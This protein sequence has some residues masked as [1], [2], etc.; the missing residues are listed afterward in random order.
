MPFLTKPSILKA[1]KTLTA[2][3]ENPAIQGATQNVS[4]LRYFFALD[5]FYF[6]RNHPC[7]TKDD[8]DKTEFAKYVGEFCSICDNLY[9]T[10]FYYPLKNHTGDFAVGSNFYSV[11]KVKDSLVNKNEYFDYPKRGNTPL[12]NI[13]AGILYKKD[14]YYN[15]INSYLSS[16]DI[17]VALVLWLLR[18]DDIETD[19]GKPIEENLYLAMGK[20]YSDNLLKILFDK[21]DEFKRIIDSYNIKFTTAGFCPLDQEDIKNLFKSQNTMNHNEYSLQVIFYGAP[22]TGKSYSIDGTT[23]KDNSIRTTFHP[24]SDY[25]SF[26]GAYKPTIQRDKGV[27]QD[28]GYS[29]EKVIDLFFHS[30]KVINEQKARYLYT[31][32]INNKDINRLGLT[33]SSIANKLKEKGFSTTAY[34]TELSA[35]LKMA[36]WLDEESNP[37]TDKIIYQFVPQAFLKAYVE[38]WKLMEEAK[39]EE[40]DAPK[41]Y[42]LVIE[43]INRGNCAQIFGDLFQL[44]DR[45]SN[46]FSSYAIVPDT[47]IQKFLMEDKMLGFGNGLTVDDVKNEEGKIIATGE[48]IRNG[49]RLVLPPNLYIRATMNTSDQSLFPIDSA[50]KRRWDWEYKKITN[51]NKDWK[52]DIINNDKRYDWWDFLEKINKLISSM[53]SSADKQLGYFFCKADK[54]KEAGSDPS[55]IKVETFVGKVLFYLWNDVFKEYG[56]DFGDLFKYEKIEGDKKTVCDLSFPDFYKEDNQVNTD[57][58]KQFIQKVFDWKPDDEK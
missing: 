40:A 56:F 7:N 4:A 52:I 43:E 10:N 34:D 12:F 48:D 28:H 18:K 6:M 26:V 36:N 19:N 54:E 16:L 29:E 9:T 49:L 44:L 32:L 35:V 1:Y 38:A 57:V 53:T 17:K 33:S 8:N 3:K 2:M 46:G 37:A 13:K 55:I 20:K 15:N 24:D 31:G 39:V 25:S 11:G 58:V 21:K 45:S 22:G 5:R 51:A 27:L 42:W 41:P 30:N 50:F 23:N 14:D 47:D